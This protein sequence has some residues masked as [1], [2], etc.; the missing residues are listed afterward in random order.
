MTTAR[1]SG[2]TA[3]AALGTGALG[4]VLVGLVHPRVHRGDIVAQIARLAPHL[5]IVHSVAIIA[6]AAL[7]FGRTVFSLRRGIERSLVLAALVVFAI[8]T[9]AIIAAGTIDGF[10]IAGVA[11]IAQ[12]P[13]THATAL[14]LFSLCA[15]G[16]DAL[17]RIGFAGYAL[18]M[19]L[20]SADLM[21]TWPRDSGLS[22]Q[23]AR[24]RPGSRSSTIF[25]A[26]MSCSR[27]MVA[28]RMW[29]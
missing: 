16:I 9:I 14:A 1:P 15:V 7:L 13:V 11:A 21:R 23:G 4:W 27:S 26:V 6:A 22:W 2:R 20:W 12:P 10:I 5:A 29:N 8:A 19:A 18:A 17:S 25:W 24:V 3:A 28:G